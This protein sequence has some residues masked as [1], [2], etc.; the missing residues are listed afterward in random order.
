M[1]T[2]F[3]KDL[4]KN[5]QLSDEAFVLK[6]FKKN[7]TKSGEEYFRFEFSDKTGTIAGNMWRDNLKNCDE[8]KIYEGC[9]SRIYAKVEEF[10]GSLQLNVISITIC[11]DYN[12][13]DFMTVS[14]QNP[15]EMWE[16]FKKHVAS[17]E[18]KDYFELVTSIFKDEKIR[19]AYRTCP[20]AES[21]HH[22]FKYGLLEHVM[23][24]LDM[25]EPLMKYYPQ[26]DK[27]LV[28]TGIILHDI[29]KIYE[30]V[31]SNTSYSKTE[32]GSLLGHIVQGYELICKFTE[33]NFPKEKLM[34]LKHI[35]LSHHGML[36]YGSPVKPM[37]I[38]A[39]I[40]SEL[41]DTSAKTR[42]YQKIMKAYEGKTEIFSERDTFLGTKIYLK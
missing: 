31:D 14:D 30:I 5:D 28:K 32:E 42:Q 29:G 20:A 39:I 33:K 25:S 38:E 24:I 1:K 3:I 37:L 17:I 16:N 27:S 41:D 26:A 21:V 15:E 36:E 2:K 9:I 22:A 8:E 40:V 18:D 11:D 4:I 6:V 7:Q 10:K 34:K 13:E 12:I 19:E 35:I 23:E